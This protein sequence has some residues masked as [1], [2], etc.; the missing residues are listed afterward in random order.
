VSF[1]RT[2]GASAG[3]PGQACASPPPRRDAGIDGNIE[4]DLASYLS[5]YVLPACGTADGCLTLE[6]YDGGAQSAPQSSGDGANAEASDAGTDTDDTS[7]SAT[8]QS[9][10][11]SGHAASGGMAV[12]FDG[13][14]VDRGRYEDV[15]RPPNNE[16]RC[17]VTCAC[18]RMAAGN[19][20]RR[21]RPHH[22]SPSAAGLER[23]PL[24]RLDDQSPVLDGQRPTG[25]PPTPAVAARLAG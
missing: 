1:H 13:D 9:E 24:R 11:S 6:N 4:S 21:H 22:E 5:T 3:L 17:V 23:R 15:R 14:L 18:H 2:G 19:D 20:G 10:G 16:W 12:A 25:R 7:T 8:E